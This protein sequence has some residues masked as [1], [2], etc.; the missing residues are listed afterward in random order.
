MSWL[1]AQTL[2]LLNQC[3]CLMQRIPGRTFGCSSRD[4]GAVLLGVSVGLS[5]SQAFVP[6]ADAWPGLLHLTLTPTLCHSRALSW[7]ML[8][9]SHF[10]FGFAGSSHRTSPFCLLLRPQSGLRAFLGHCLK[11]AP[12]PLICPP[13]HNVSYTCFYFLTQF[14][15]SSDV[16]ICPFPPHRSTL[17]S[18]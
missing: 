15:C 5:P 3:F 9:H 2:G 13:P 7:N 11:A 17:C 6:A 4:A 8:G 12:A 18:E 10:R 14:V 16:L 1:A